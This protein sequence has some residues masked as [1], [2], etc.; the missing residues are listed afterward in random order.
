[1]KQLLLKSLII[2]PVLL[3]LDWTIMIVIGCISNICGANINYFNTIYYYF[4]VILL[5]LTLLFVG[6]ILFK[7]YFHRRLNFQL[8]K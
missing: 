2:I 6:A 4:G 7:Q 1:M 3:F 5:L 8:K